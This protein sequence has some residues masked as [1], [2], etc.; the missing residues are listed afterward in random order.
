MRLRALQIGCRGS[1]PRA[2]FATAP[3]IRNGPG[4]QLQC[5]AH[6]VNRLRLSDHPM[7]NTGPKTAAWVRDPIAPTG[8]R[9]GT[10]AADAGP[11]K[12]PDVDR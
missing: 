2:R 9:N 10:S 12:V 8:R 11:I 5:Q 6:G 7:K 3:T 1:A 4:P